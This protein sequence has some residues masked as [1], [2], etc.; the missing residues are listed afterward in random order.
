MGAASDE[1]PRPVA[2][3]IGEKFVT[4]K[5]CSLQG[6]YGGCRHPDSKRDEQMLTGV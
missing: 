4:P 3:M 6:E 1:S 2:E 5:G